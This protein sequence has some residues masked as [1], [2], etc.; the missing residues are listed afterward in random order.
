MFK[1][2][3]GVIK[4]ILDNQE[5]RNIF[6]FL[7]LNLA[8]MVIQMMYGV[9]TNSLGLIS[10]SIHMFFDCMA[11][12]MGLFAS[13]MAT[14]PPDEEFTHGYGRVQTLSG[15]A[16][17]IFLMLISIF[18]VIE[19]IQRLLNPPEM[20]T[21]KL[22]IVSFMGLVVNLV[23]MFCTGHHH[24]HHHGHS[25]SHDHD[26]HDDDH[27]HHHHHHHHGDGKFISHGKIIFLTTV[28]Y[29]TEKLNL[30]FFS[31][32]K[33]LGHSHN[34]K[35][36]FLHVMAD[37]LGSVG[38][39]ISTILIERYGWT[40]FD[41]IA[42]IF[43]ALLIFASVVPLV[44]DSAKVLIL[45]LGAEKE[46]KVRK[47]LNQLSKIEGLSSYSMPRFWP[48][49]PSKISGSI[50]LQLTP[51]TSTTN[52]LKT[53]TTLKK[54][55][56]KADRDDLELISSCSTDSSISLSSSSSG[57][58]IVERLR[59][60]GGLY[61]GFYKDC[62]RVKGDVEKVLYE[63]IEGLDEL[64]IQIEGVDGI[65]SCFC[66]TRNWIDEDGANNDLDGGSNIQPDH[67]IFQ[68]QQQQRG[69]G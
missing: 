30:F 56:K 33:N 40:G 13:V 21:N 61:E 31:K 19:A 43:I 14:W 66:L 4:T 62:E 65:K 67:G 16:N 51:R 42:S 35:G 48:K 34:M 28:L 1:K 52:D 60:G 55:K 18:I 68:R 15:F 53:A 3:S 44:Q 27:H 57:D 9:W 29:T 36:V 11:L 25:H 32:K 46:V 54:R 8:Y 63:G 49:D 2:L 38:V 47:A 37:T 17:G 24:H 7:C 12:G 20:N 26:H 50:H 10:D 23:G 22:L 64:V 6:F 41:P 39:I 45:E 5:S 59:R 69:G 58:L